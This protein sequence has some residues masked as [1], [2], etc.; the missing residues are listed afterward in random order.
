MANVNAIDML[1][2]QHDQVDEL[3]EELDQL[4]DEDG[5][6]KENLFATLADKLAIHATI[7]ERHFYPA[8]KAK[9]TEDILLE[10][11]EEHLAIKRVLADLLGLDVDDDRWQ[12]KLEVLREE[13]EHHVEEER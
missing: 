6:Q 7:E 2:E 10:S 4:D 3:F 8:V 5:G 11:L 12:A 13:V 9:A 1:D